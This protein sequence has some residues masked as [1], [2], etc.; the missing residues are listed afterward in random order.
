MIV[1]M[2]FHLVFSIYG[3]IFSLPIQVPSKNI[4]PIAKPEPEVVAMLTSGLTASISLER[5]WSHVC[6]IF[7]QT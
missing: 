2:L 7:L 5:V 1:L 6:F 4:I 3:L